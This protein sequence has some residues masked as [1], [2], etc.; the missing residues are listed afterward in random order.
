MSCSVV[1]S[2]S[3]FF[4]SNVFLK[5]MGLGN[6]IR[7]PGLDAWLWL[8]MPGHAR[9]QQVIKSFLSPM[10]DTEMEFSA[11]GFGLGQPQLSWAFTE[12]NLG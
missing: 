3:L 2:L 11:P 6:F 1:S 9:R 5:T 4:Y 12:Y 10:G 7:V 8:P